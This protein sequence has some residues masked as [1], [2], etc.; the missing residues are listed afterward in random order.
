VTCDQLDNEADDGLLASN[1]GDDAVTMADDRN[2]GVADDLTEDD[3][4]V[5]DDDLAQKMMCLHSDPV[6]KLVRVDE[7]DNK[8]QQTGANV[9]RR[10]SRLASII[11]RKEKV[12]ILY[13]STA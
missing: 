7:I 9:I 13:F 10:S 1:N 3:D 11:S 12:D 4:E 8:S 5:N 2:G 6:V